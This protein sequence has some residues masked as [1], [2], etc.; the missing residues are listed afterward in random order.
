MNCLYVMLLNA[1]L[2]TGTILYLM[3]KLVQKGKSGF[4]L[5]VLQEARLVI[6]QIVKA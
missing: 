4:F 1:S 6:T 2:K 3:Q 5:H